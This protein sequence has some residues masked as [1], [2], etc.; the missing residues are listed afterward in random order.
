M[1]KVWAAVLAAALVA[2]AAALVPGLAPKVEAHAPQPIAKS[3]RLD[4]KAYG[5]ACSQRSWPN[6]EASCL[7]NATSPTREARPVRVVT[8]DRLPADIVRGRTAR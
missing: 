3:D 4:V 1:N 6:Y 7:R 5:P 2:C 8:T